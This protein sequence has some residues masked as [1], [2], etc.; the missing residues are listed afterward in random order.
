MG[1]V[2]STL[3]WLN[4]VLQLV[5]KHLDS[6]RMSQHVCKIL[7]IE[8]LDLLHLITKKLKYCSLQVSKVAGGS[9]F[10][11]PEQKK[12]LFKTNGC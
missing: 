10:R 3:N 1:N 6:F 5:G 7:L 8:I 4:C 11:L 2:F 9:E 12:T